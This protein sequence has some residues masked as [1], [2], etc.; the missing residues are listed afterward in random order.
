MLPNSPV[1]LEDDSRSAGAPAFEIE[2]TPEMITAGRMKISEV[3]FDFISDH[4]VYI[5][6]E[7]LTDVYLAMCE[8]SPRSHR[9]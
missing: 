2:V 3:W 1:G 6:N 5:W 9:K 8:A 4:G 7:L